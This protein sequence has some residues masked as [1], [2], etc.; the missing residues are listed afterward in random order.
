[1]HVLFLSHLRCQSVVISRLAGEQDMC[2]AFLLP[3]HDVSESTVVLI[4]S[5]VV[6]QP[7]VEN[8]VFLLC[9][10][11]LYRAVQM[12]LAIGQSRTWYGGG[13]T[14]EVNQSGPGAKDIT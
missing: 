13:M 3:D 10:L 1:M 4:L 14:K 2:E 11:P 8:V 5:H 7:L 6:S 12:H 9:D